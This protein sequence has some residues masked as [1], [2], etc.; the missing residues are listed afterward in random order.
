MPKEVPLAFVVGNRCPGG[1]L[2]IGLISGKPKTG[3]DNECG[4]H[5]GSGGLGIVIGYGQPGR[6]IN[7]GTV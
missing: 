3:W 7:L 6:F 4:T 2:D 5:T 1:S